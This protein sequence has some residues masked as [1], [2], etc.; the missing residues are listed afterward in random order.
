MC[1]RD[2]YWDKKGDGKRLPKGKKVLE[3]SLDRRPIEEEEGGKK[4]G[5]S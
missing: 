1:I 4:E 5:K 3:I 2:R